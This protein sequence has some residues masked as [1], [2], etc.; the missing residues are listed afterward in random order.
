MAVYDARFASCEP[1]LT[2]SNS[3]ILEIGVLGSATSRVWPRVGYRFVSRMS[4]R[5]REPRPVQF[6][7]RVVG[8]LSVRRE[9]REG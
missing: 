5:V 7:R 1:Y 6:I 3:Y 8:G 9:E 2:L 4:E